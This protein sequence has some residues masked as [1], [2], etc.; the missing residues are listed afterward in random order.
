[1]V[2][3]AFGQ[4]VTLLEQTGDA[5]WLSTTA[6]WL[7]D[8]RLRIAMEVRSVLP[9]APG[10]I[11]VALITGD[12]GAIPKPVLEAMRD[13]GLS[14]LLSISGLHIGLVA[15]ILFIGLRAMLALIPP[16]V[17]N[18]PT[19]KWAAATALLGTLFYLLLAGAPVPTQRAYLMTG[20]VLLAV[21]FDRKAISMRT[22][23]LAATAVLLILPDALVGASFQ[24][25][26]AAVVA[27]VAVYEASEPLR[28]RWRANAPWPRTAA[29]Y[30]GGIAAMSLIATAAT[31]PFVAY[32]F[33][34]FTAYGVFANMLAVP[35]TSFW[36]MP[37]AVAAVL[38]MP[39]GLA[40]LA[41]VPMG[42]GIEGIVWIA[43]VVAA[44]PGAVS[45][46]PAMPI[47][48]LL[49]TTLG[50]LWLC[51]WQRRWRLLGLPA[52]GLGLLSVLM[53]RPPDIL[54]SEDGRLVAVADGDGKLLLSS[55]R[56][57]R[58]EADAWLLR[59]GEDAALDWP[60]DG[61]GAG[62]RLACDNLGC[63][64]SAAGWTVAIAHEPDALIEDCQVADIVLSLE[65]MR[66][67]CRS[68]K[69]VIDRFDLWRDGAH[70]LWIDDE[71]AVR[72]ESV[73]ARRGDRPW[74]VQPGREVGGTSASEPG[75][76]RDRVRRVRT[77]GRTAGRRRASRRSV[78]R[79]R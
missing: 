63:I 45:L 61:Y 19:K 50:G 36:V 60:T 43:D 49:L 11:A 6:A 73:R 26:F 62:G 13:S 74:V 5:D 64:Y 23:A 35:L 42:W 29:L 28:L 18:H 20:I 38:L 17:L 59:A 56:V 51:L 66:G 58:F 16:L 4:T 78:L 7:A 46:V 70:A 27:L 76:L 71:Q 8:L 53:V 68:A 40:W 22:V 30:V 33:D 14:H 48:G 10:A 55:R 31:S 21:L 75:G 79:G 77:R 25:S 44:L 2:G 65:P 24:M 57:G 72:I 34:R 9:E 32:H 39:F 54:I 1:A 69:R 47:G 12:Q 37:F 41:L 67:P 15:G 52:I 3:F